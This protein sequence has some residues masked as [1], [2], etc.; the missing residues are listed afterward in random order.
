MLRSVEILRR[1]A[2]EVVGSTVAL[3]VRCVVVVLDV[4]GCV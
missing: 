2:L 4:Y 3:V 1:F